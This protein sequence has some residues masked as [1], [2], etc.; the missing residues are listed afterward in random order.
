MITISQLQTDLDRIKD[1]Y[2]D[3]PICD[4]E[5]HMLPNLPPEVSALPPTGMSVRLPFELT[6][7]DSGPEIKKLVKKLRSEIDDI[8]IN[9]WGAEKAADRLEEA[10]GI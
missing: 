4:A 8:S 6:G 9:K 1:A 3:L 7:L 5:G 2:G 10:L